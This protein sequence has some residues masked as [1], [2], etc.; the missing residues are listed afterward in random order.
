M[1]EAGEPHGNDER[2][3]LQF[4]GPEREEHT[5][6]RAV[7]A[8]KGHESLTSRLA[9]AD[10]NALRLGVTVV[11]WVII[12]VNAM[13]LIW[14]LNEN[15]LGTRAY[16]PDSYWD[17]MVM[18]TIV[19]A[20]TCAIS[21]ALGVLLLMVGRRRLVASVS[22]ILYPTLVVLG[23]YLAV[24]GVSQLLFV[25][26]YSL[27]STVQFSFSLELTVEGTARIVGGV[28]LV[29]IGRGWLRAT[30]AHAV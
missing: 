25:V 15:P 11:G 9:E 16:W 7:D 4:P 22:E 17:M 2:I 19:T 24:A 12:V 29:L 21:V 6:S 20:V 23:L 3:R 10:A 28:L 18:Q 27:T 13:G 14:W 5:R 1:A 30:T 8:T 26:S